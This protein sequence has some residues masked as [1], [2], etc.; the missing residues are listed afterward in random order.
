MTQLL[1]IRQIVMTMVLIGFSL[2]VYQAIGHPV[3]GLVILMLMLKQHTASPQDTYISTLY[4]WVAATGAAQSSDEAKAR[5]SDVGNA[6][7]FPAELLTKDEIAYGSAKSRI[8]IANK[9]IEIAFI[10]Y[11]MADY[12]S[13]VARTIYP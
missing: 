7:S 3:S 9:V 5:L 4:A 6:V 2:I 13:A 1:A 8:D 11:L 12:L 10:L